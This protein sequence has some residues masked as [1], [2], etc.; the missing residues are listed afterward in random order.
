MTTGRYAQTVKP[1][2][3]TWTIGAETFKAFKDFD[4]DQIASTHLKFTL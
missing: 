2:T 1:N 4:T 3:P